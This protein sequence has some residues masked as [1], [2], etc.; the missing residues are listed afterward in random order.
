MTMFFGENFAVLTVFGIT[1]IDMPPT[2]YRM[3]PYR[4]R[5]AI[6]VAGS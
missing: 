1:Y 6:R 4:I 2:P 3:A 5:Q